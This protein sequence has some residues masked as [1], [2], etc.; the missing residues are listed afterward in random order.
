MRERY[1]PARRTTCSGS[2]DCAPRTRASASPR[3]PAPSGRCRSCSSARP[4]RWAREL[5]GRAAHRHGRRRRAGGDL[6][7]RPRARVPQR[8][9][10]L[11]PAPGRG[12]GLRHAGGG[13]RRP[14]PA[15]G[16]RRPGRAERDRRPRRARARRRGAARGPPPRP[17]AWSWADAARATWT[18]YHEALSAPASRL[19]APASAHRGGRSPNGGSSRRRRLSPGARSPDRRRQPQ[20]WRR[21]SRCAPARRARRRWRGSSR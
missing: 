4:S 19:T 17:P 12:A 7:R 6:H 1:S 15:R 13:L 20:T 21:R 5:P 3:W 14:G 9:R 10:G 18:V 11:R 8:R 16:A 2:G